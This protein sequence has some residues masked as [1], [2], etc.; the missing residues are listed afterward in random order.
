M[1]KGAFAAMYGLE[2]K[3]LREKVKA[4]KK[5]VADL[6]IDKNMRKLKDLKS[7][8]KRKKELA[9]VLTVVRQKELFST[10]EKKGRTEL[11]KNKK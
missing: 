2:P 10:M 5:E 8:S 9:Q 7:I 11:S 3:E 6:V 1:K 4:L